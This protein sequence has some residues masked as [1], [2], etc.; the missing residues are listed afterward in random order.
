MNQEGYITANDQEQFMQAGP[1]GLFATLVGTVTAQL[2]QQGGG[3]AAPALAPA[4]QPDALQPAPEPPTLEQYNY[5]DECNQC[6]VCLGQM[7]YDSDGA[8]EGDYCVHCNVDLHTNC[9]IYCTGCSSVM[10]PRCAETYSTCADCA[11][12]ESEESE[13]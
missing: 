12:E 6:E 4:P 1:D 13:D 8:Y 5:S 7:G 10:C 3:Y 9:G 11:S 2:Q